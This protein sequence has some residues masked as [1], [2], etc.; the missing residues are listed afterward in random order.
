MDRKQEIELVSLEEL[1][2]REYRM[3]DTPNDMAGFSRSTPVD[4]FMELNDE[5]MGEDSEGVT[6]REKHSRKVLLN[7]PLPAYQP[8][9]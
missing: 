2:E 9:G 1:Q 4:R 3:H 5:S 6:L 8:H 7:R